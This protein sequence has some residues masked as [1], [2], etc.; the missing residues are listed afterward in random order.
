METVQNLHG[1]PK[2]IVCDKDPVFIGN[3]WTEL[4]YCLGT[5]LAH[6]SSYH[7]RSNE[8]TNIL[9]KHLEG[10]LHCFSYDKQTQWVKWFSLAE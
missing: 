10:Y 6:I 3:F 9:D 1:V 5:Q 2:I 8:K 7:P 4:F